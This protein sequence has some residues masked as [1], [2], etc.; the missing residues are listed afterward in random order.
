MGRG[1]IFLIP[2]FRFI[3]NS[4]ADITGLDEGVKVAPQGILTGFNVQM[5]ND[6]GA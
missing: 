2:A 3:R 6:F 5:F 1:D 4:Q